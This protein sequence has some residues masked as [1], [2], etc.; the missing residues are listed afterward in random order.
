MSFSQTV[1]K[2]DEKAIFQL[3]DLYN[4]YGYSLYKVSKFEEYDLYAR[5]KS[6]LVS[7]NI[8]SFTDTNGKLMA[9]KPDVTLSIIKNIPDGDTVTH[10][11]CY[12]ETVYRTST[13]SDGFREIMQTGLECIGTIDLYAECEVLMLAMRSLQTISNTYILDLSHMGILEGLFDEAGIIGADRT[14]LI[15]LIES[16][17]T[18]SLVTLCQSKKISEDMTE[19]LRT[20]TEL[21][22]PIKEALP[23]LKQVLTGKKMAQAYENLQSIC[24]VMDAYELTDRLYLDFSVVNDVSYYDGICF[25]GFVH[26]IPESV[27]SGGRYDRLLHRLKK[28]SGA[29]GFAVYLDRLERL[30]E[31]AQSKNYDA[32]VVLQYEQGIPSTEILK[33]QS[34]LVSDGNRV[35]TVSDLDPTLRYRRLIKITNGG[36][37]TLEIH[38]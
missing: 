32:D 27:L 34:R 35:I 28:Q 8:L 38:D 30:E 18:H 26:E 15:H 19:K 6:F 1:L 31:D 16:K 33:I 36:T 23:I 21:Y 37:Q 25:K 12:N 7:Q 13:D 22:L 20:L 4:R 17:N 11:F 24:N 2:N 10:K 14:D 29:I 5:N 9:L 3:R